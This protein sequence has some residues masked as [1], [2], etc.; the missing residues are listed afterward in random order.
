MKKMIN[1]KKIENILTNKSLSIQFRSDNIQ[2]WN[3]TLRNIEY[4]PADFCNDLIDFY[5]S[6]LRSNGFIC[7]DYSF[8]IYWGN[9]L[10]GCFLCS[11][12]TKKNNNYF[13]NFGKPLNQPL[14]IKDLNRK[15]KKNIIKNLLH[16]IISINRKL[17]KN[18][19]ELTD[20]F[21]N[22]LGASEWCLYTASLSLKNYFSYELFYKVPVNCSK[23][24]STWNKK[25]N[26]LIKN[27]LSYWDN[28]LLCYSSKN[29]DKIFSEF[30]QLHFR[31]SG[32]KTR[33]DETWEIQKK[34]IKNNTS[35]LVYLIDDNKDMI[36]AGYFTFTKTECMYAV[37]AYDRALFNKPIGHIVQFLAIKYI[38]NK[39]INWYKI[40]NLPFEKSKPIP[41]EKEISISQ[42]KKQFSTDI[43]MQPFFK[44]KLN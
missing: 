33:S 2:K 14:F 19:I 9:K 1:K 10:A 23:I 35:F 40:G 43:I 4:V 25:L 30:K 38:I 16:F 8:T 29:I 21:T 3:E 34:S 6:N 39:K 36:G 17:S 22:N 5:A 18:F 24:N 32:R 26:S 28:G 27:N 37:G 20:V 7:I 13:N 41:T 42:F 44:I 31:V 11:L 15:T 12:S